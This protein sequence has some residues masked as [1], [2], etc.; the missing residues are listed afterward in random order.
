MASYP[1]FT[2]IVPALNEQST[3]QS[4]LQSLLELDYPIDRM[5]IIVS[6]N[7]S[8]DNTSSVV[9]Q[10]IQR[11]PQRNI[12]LINHP[13][14]NKGAALNRALKQARGEFFA[15]L[16][17]DS[18]IHPDALRE[19]LPYFAADPDVAAVCPLMKVKSPQT[20]L[21]KIQWYEYIINMF[22]KFLNSQL[23]AV[24]VTPGPFS[25][26][27]TAVIKKI[28]W[29]D[30]QTITEDLEIAIRLQKYHYRIIQTFDALVET[31]AP[32]TWKALFR[33]RV[34][35]YKG[36]VDNSLRY[37]ELIFNQRYGDFGMI[38]M[39]TIILSGVLA[40]IILFTFLKELLL[41]LF[42]WLASLQAINFDY[43]AVLKSYTFQINILSLPFFKITIVLT[44]VS[45]SFLAMVCSYKLVKED[46]R[47]HGRTLVSLVTYLSIYSVFMTIV[48]VYIAA[49]FLARK[50]N[51]WS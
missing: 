17:A 43:L 37:R 28:G 14:A 46:I 44:L 3:I 51:R 9:E 16:D 29:Y 22:Y 42:H 30:E 27:K 5:E 4:T 31:T 7:G 24:H 49:L 34:R 32:D 21:Q 19:M 13:R 39:P 35:W 18:F 26:Y 36:S 12:F 8:S 23:D 15:C 1:F 6:I 41:N 11:H 25:V 10:F 33:Q 48:W 50:R 20:V 47:N 45:L 40:I 2:A 38:R